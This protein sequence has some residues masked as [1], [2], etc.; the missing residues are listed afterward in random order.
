MSL[1]RD[2]RAPRRV[3]F[4][5]GWQG[6]QFLYVVTLMGSPKCHCLTRLSPLL[7]DYFHF[8]SVALAGSV[9]VSPLT[10]TSPAGYRNGL[11]RPSLFTFLLGTEN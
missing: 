10:F 1:T 6:W 7:P 5:R 4:R 2:A 9:A 8:H 3:A 11:G